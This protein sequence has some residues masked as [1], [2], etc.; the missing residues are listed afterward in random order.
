M[1]FLIKVY[2]KKISELLCV[3]WGKSS[4]EKISWNQIG[5]YLVN[6]FHDLFF[7]TGE[8]TPPEHILDGDDVPLVEEV[9]G[10]MVGTDEVQNAIS[11]GTGV[12]G[13]NFLDTV[14]KMNKHNNI[15]SGGDDESEISE[16][17]QKVR[18]KLGLELSPN[19]SSS[20]TKKKSNS[21]KR[22]IENGLGQVCKWNFNFYGI[23]DLV[24]ISFHEF[25]GL[26]FFE[27]LKFN[28]REMKWVNLTNM[29]YLEQE[30]I[31]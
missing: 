12:T 30:N 3:V 27:N 19:K 8:S 22:K 24:C 5:I 16:F 20:S 14:M 2:K 25:F 29:F 9:L 21:K 15:N 4:N 18:E 23:W 17:E 6:L 28:T 1:S 13:E 11:N 10:D 7:F 31:I 26:D